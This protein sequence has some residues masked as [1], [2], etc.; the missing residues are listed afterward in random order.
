MADGERPA[1]VVDGERLRVLQVRAARGRVADVANRER[2]RQV[3]E[4]LLAERVL[5]EPHGAVREE[6]LPVARDDA[7][8][9]LAAVLE[10]V[11]PEVGEVG[12]LG[13]AVDGEDAALVVEVVVAVVVVSMS[14][15]ATDGPG[16][17]GWVEDDEMTAGAD[18]A[19]ANLVLNRSP[20]KPFPPVCPLLPRG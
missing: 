11:E 3:P 19:W 5:D 12:G 7:G 4:L 16:R 14:R 17:G 1:R 9:L 18:H 8:R 13:V 20:G 10:G 15:H 6:L 2:P